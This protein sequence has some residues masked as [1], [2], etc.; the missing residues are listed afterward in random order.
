LFGHLHQKNSEHGVRDLSSETPANLLKL[1][2]KSQ[3]A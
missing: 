1:G 3:D 2:F